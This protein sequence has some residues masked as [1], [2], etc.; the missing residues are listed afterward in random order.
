[1]KK[2]ISL[3]LALLMAFSVVTVAF[4]TEGEA[5]DESTATTAPADENEEEGAESVIDL[6]EYQWILDLPFWTVKPALKFAKIAFKLVKVYL[7][8]GK[9]F[10]VV[11]QDMGDIILGAISDLI[12][13]SMKGESAE[14]TTEVDTTAAEAA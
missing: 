4:A 10:G 5:A 6:G 1:M 12:E 9:I 13:N 14:E 11:E 2:I 8:V 7:K 3:L